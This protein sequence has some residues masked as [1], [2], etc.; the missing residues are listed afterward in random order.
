IQDQSENRTVLDH[1]PLWLGRG[2]GCEDEVCQAVGIAAFLDRR[3]RILFEDS[4]IELEVSPPGAG[5]PCRTSL[6]DAEDSVISVLRKLAFSGT[7]YSGV[8]DFRDLREII[9]KVLQEAS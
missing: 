8:L 9:T 7:R 5:H 1:H 6:I 3:P 2:S 4:S